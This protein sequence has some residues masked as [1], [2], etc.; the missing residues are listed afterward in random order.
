MEFLKQVLLLLKVATEAEALKRIEELAAL[1]APDPLLQELSKQLKEANVEAGQ[2]RE[3]LDA[4]KEHRAQLKQDMETFA[5]LALCDTE[6]SQLPEGFVE[7]QANLST[8]Q[9]A[10][11]VKFYRLQAEKKFPQKCQDCGSTNVSSRTS[12][13]P[14]LGEEPEKKQKID[15]SK[16]HG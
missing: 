13:K 3:L 8:R 1:P 9:M 16:I 4:G 15:V 10:N 14:L 5:K 6:G 2:F 7:S 11:Q 12:A